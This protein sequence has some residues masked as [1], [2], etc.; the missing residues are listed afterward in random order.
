[1]VWAPLF[2]QGKSGTDPFCLFSPPLPTLVLHV[3]KK[4]NIFYSLSISIRLSIRRIGPLLSIYLFLWPLWLCQ[5][6]V[7]SFLSMIL[8]QVS[9][10]CTA[11]LSFTILCPDGSFMDK[12]LEHVSILVTCFNI[13]SRGLGRV[14]TPCT[15]RSI[16][17]LPT[18]GHIY[19]SGL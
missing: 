1:M 5:S 14:V 13:G 9:L 12:W 8:L 19:V 10:I 2:L 15:V 4:I 17:P 6:E 7:L 11:S 16:D 18:S 3:C